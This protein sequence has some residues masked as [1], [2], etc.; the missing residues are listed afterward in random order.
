MKYHDK[1]MCKLNKKYTLDHEYLYKKFRNHVVSELKT[2]R[3][4]HYN[5]YFTE[6]KNNMKMLWTGIRSIILMQKR[7]IK[8]Y[9]PNYSSW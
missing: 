9:L 8:Q 1:L 5:K 7:Q 4:N 2:S 3:I 6:H